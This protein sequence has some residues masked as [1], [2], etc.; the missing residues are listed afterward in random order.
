MF[1]IETGF[2]HVG[3]AGFELPISG[4][5]IALA[6][7][8]AEITGV[9]HCAQPISAD[10]IHRIRITLTLLDNGKRFPKWLHHLYTHGQCMK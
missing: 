4:D 5:P 6:S 3:Q 2:L 10:F 7:Q 8:S 9:S 1:L